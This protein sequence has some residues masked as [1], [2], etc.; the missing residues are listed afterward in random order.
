MTKKAV[1]T[2]GASG[3]GLATAQRFMAAG[4][5]VY[6]CD[7]NEAAI[8]DVIFQNPGLKGKVASV[9]SVADVESFFRYVFADAGGVDVLVNNAGIGGPR[10][11]VDEIS[12]ADWDDCIQVNL[13]GMFYCVKQ[14]VPYM[15]KKQAGTIINIS[16]AST[17][18]GLINRLPYI[19]SKAGVLG[20]SYNLARELGPYN[21][22]SNAILPGLIDN[23]RGRA[24]VSTIAE[25]RGVTTEQQEQE[26]LKY[27]SMSTWI[28]PS[29]IGDMAVFLASDTARHVTGQEISV[30]GNLEWEY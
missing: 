6:I 26:F 20:F 25:Q 11:A 5:D 23:P 9:S 3:I 8:A 16:T 29:E 12:Y 30:D 14:V 15:K 10:A 17:K 27:I 21:I 24:L 7:I 18:T 28:A 13:S 4:Y 1:V 22:R 19:A 2:A